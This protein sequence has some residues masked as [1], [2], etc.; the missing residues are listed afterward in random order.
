MTISSIAQRADRLFSLFRIF[1]VA[2]VTFAGFG[3]LSAQCNSGEVLV[4]EDADNYYCMQKS[5]YESSPA[6][7]LAEQFCRTKRLLV[8]DQ[9]AIRALGFA[10]DTQ[11][12]E[13][14]ADTAQEQK[15][16]L[17]H[18]LFDTFVDQS[19]DASVMAFRSAKSLNPWNVNNTINMLRAKGF[20]STTVISALRKIAAQK[21]KPAMFEAYE[22]FV[23]TA[24]QVKEEWNTA[25]DVTRDRQNAN[26]RILLGALKVI[27]G[28]PQ[29]GALVTSVEFGENLAYLYY[30]SGEVNDLGKVS[31][32]KL[33]Q[34][35]ELSGKLRSDLSAMVQSKRGWQRA[36]GYGKGSP[37]CK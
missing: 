34:L 2:V 6:K 29:L 5:K 15:S 7:A 21:D 22:E 19:L 33:K 30:L 11:R 8:A 28:D 20:E 10:T 36:T 31:D 12:F 27:Q 14:F 37:V 26:L 25:S 23:E 35:S 1:A 3:S 18:K 16:D 24:K 9:N 17:E 13:L 32:Q 4:G